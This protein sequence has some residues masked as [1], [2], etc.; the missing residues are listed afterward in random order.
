MI[1]IFDWGHETFDEVG[2]LS[3]SDLDFEVHGE[4]YILGKRKKWF[5]AFFIRTLPTETNYGLIHEASGEFI[6]L[7]EEVFDRFKPLAELNALAMED[8]ISDED[9]STRRANLG[10]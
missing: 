8:M 2:P 5:R 6:P 9:Y 1:F 10:F 3:R 4:M 7:S